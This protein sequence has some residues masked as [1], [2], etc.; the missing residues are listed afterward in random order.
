MQDSSPRVAIVTGAAGGLGREIALQLAA[1][2]CIVGALDIAAE[3][4]RRRSPLRTGCG[5]AF[6]SWQTTVKMPAA[7]G[8]ERAANIRP[9][10]FWSTCGSG[11]WLAG[12]DA[13]LGAHV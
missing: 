1:R 10:D 8:P 3:G 4:A 5:R 11:W 7:T 2:G 13:A 9:H 12:D 6:A